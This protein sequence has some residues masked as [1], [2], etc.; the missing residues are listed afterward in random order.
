MMAS[1]LLARKENK[2]ENVINKLNQISN[3]LSPEL[4]LLIAD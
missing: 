1:W 4:K 3:K 2:I